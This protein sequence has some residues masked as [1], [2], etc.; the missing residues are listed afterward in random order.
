MHIETKC[1]MYV[2]DR[3]MIITDQQALRCNS[4]RCVTLSLLAASQLVLSL[5]T[6]AGQPSYIVGLGS[7]LGQSGQGHRDSRPIITPL[8]MSDSAK[9]MRRCD[10]NAEGKGLQKQ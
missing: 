5:L 9:L 2:N 7:Q 4:A 8:L 3:S 1:L 6:T 10:H